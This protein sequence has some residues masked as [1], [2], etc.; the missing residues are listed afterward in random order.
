M[1][2]KSSERKL[3]FMDM[4]AGVTLPGVL[5]G[6]TAHPQEDIRM[7]VTKEMCK[8]HSRNLEQYVQNVLTELFLNL[9]EV[10]SQE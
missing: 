8:I 6:A 5:Q 7:Q 9:N 4:A 10:G 2:Q 3:V 1:S